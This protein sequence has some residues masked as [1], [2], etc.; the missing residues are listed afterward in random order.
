MEKLYV[1]LIITLLH[2]N[3]VIVLETPRLILRT[4][5]WQDLDGLAV[6]LLILP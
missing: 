6:I 2:K 1:V 4:F 5:T 3:Q